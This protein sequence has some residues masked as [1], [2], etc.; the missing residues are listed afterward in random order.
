MIKIRL[1]RRHPPIV[2]LNF[3]LQFNIPYQNFY[4]L[5]SYSILL[6]EETLEN[7]QPC[8]SGHFK[9]LVFT[10]QLGRCSGDA[11]CVGLECWEGGI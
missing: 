5:K 1:A 4:S 7:I 2:K 6:K 8:S 9:G 11:G 3:H 10:G